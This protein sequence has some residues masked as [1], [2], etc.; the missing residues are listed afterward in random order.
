ML[1]P[2]TEQLRNEL[3]AG[4]IGLERFN[5]LDGIAAPKRN[6]WVAAPF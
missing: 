6:E 3:A 2:C 1:I 5:A 4:V